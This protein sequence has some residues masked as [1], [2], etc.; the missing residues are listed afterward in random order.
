VWQAK[1]TAVVRVAYRRGSQS[2]FGRGLIL[3]TRLIEVAALRHGLVLVD[4]V[5]Q[6]L[7]DVDGPNAARADG[8]GRERVEVGLWQRLMMPAPR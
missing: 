8:E 2:G 5:V 6:G 7:Q 4:A 3:A 1:R